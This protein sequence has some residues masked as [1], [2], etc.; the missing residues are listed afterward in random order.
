MSDEKIGRDVEK[1][2]STGQFVEKLRRLADA[3]E[4]RQPFTIQ[5]ANQRLKVPAD[6][7]ISIEHEQS[8]GD[9]ELEFQLTWSEQPN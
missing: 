6:A 3:L 8:G 9:H 7:Q 2:Y 5:V 4:A 1:V